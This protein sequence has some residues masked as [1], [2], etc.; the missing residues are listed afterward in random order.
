MILKT[1]LEG[2]EP[3]NLRTS[4]FI[5]GGVIKACVG[6]GMAEEDEGEVAGVGL[7][8]RMVTRWIRSSSFSKT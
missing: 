8:S 7:F 2:S 5:F 1:H 6:A 4:S 3:S